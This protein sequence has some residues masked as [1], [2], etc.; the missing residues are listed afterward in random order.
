GSSRTVTGEDDFGQP[1]ELPNPIDFRRSSASQSISAGL[2]LF[3]G[4]SRV[5]SLRAARAD[6]RAVAARISASEQRLIADVS[7]RYYLAL[8]ARRRIAL[9]EQLLASARER[10]EMTEEQLR[11]VG[12]HPED[13]LG[14]QV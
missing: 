2:T 13:V 9:E 5:N 8:R 1:V 6:S 12:T 11:V 14:A 4:L 3:D 10:L 7:Q